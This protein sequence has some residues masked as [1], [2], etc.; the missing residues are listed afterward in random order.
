MTEDRNEMQH[1]T[2]K[3]LNTSRSSDF[4]NMTTSSMGTTTKDSSA[5]TS[6]TNADIS[7]SQQVQQQQQQQ[8]DASPVSTQ[9]NKI[10]KKNKKDTEKKMLLTDEDF[11]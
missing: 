9:I 5:S 4:N 2:K 3:E 11:N 8:T 7:L 10:L 6:T 1:H